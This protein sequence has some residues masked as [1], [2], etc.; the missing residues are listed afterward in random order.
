MRALVTGANR[1]LGF[2]FTRQLLARGAHVIAACRHPGRA[3]KLTEQAA[4][5]PGRLHVLPLD[6]AK[7]RS[8]IELAREA[9]A[10][11][12]SLDVLINNAGM[13][14][15]G[16]R[17][18]EV[19]AKS[20]DE[21]FATNVTGPFLLTQA[22]APLLEKGAQPKVMNLSSGLGSIAGAESFGTASYSISKAALNMATRQ[23]AAALHTREVTVV[24]MSPGWVSTDMGGAG[25]PLKPDA[26]VRGMLQVLDR[27]TLRDSGKFF[28]H[29][30]GTVAW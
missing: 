19:S 3:A 8:I 4:A 16:E 14:V 25:A 18:G 23:L 20:L 7:E 1:G 15:S 10:L 21:T 6:L 17:F 22:L 26:S 2:E 28:D 27:V 29:G 13:L 24:A 12:E 30:G 11:F 9:A 5:H